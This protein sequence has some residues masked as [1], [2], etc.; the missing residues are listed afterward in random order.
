MTS[1]DSYSPPIRVVTL[2]LGDLIAG[3][4][5][6]PNDQR[7]RLGFDELEPQGAKLWCSGNL[8][9]VH[10]R[11]VSIVGT[12][13][14]SPA[15]AKRA[16]RLARELVEAG[17]V[18]VSGLARGVDTFALTSA[19]ENGGEVIAVIGTPINEAYPAENRKLQ[20]LIHREHLLISQ[21]APGSPIYKS[22]F[23]DRNRMMAAISD[24]TV[25]VEA[26]N[27]SGT[28]HQA[29]E[30][31]RLQRWLFFPRSLMEMPEV[32]W[33]S[34]FIRPSQPR[35]MIFDNTSQILDSIRG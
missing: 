26:G 35:T 4:R 25:I 9:L 31:Q 33:P 27:S 19:I 2:T 32:N 21:F 28:K 18:V 6:I 29:S 16:K 34:N 12:R 20:E 22:N 5:V 30:S 13:N 8:A 3:S 23:P 11:C 1:E 10:K 7:G 14:V 17:I 15:G 24:A